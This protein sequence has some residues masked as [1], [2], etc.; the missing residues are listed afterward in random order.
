MFYSRYA[1]NQLDKKETDTDPWTRLLCQRPAFFSFLFT[2]A[3]AAAPMIVRCG[4][5]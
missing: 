1:G 3:A 2:P 5:D 4:Y